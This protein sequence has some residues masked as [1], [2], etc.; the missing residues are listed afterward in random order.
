MNP[1]PE[2]GDAR[3]AAEAMD[4]RMHAIAGDIESVTFN[5][6]SA[7]VSRKT[8]ELRSNDVQSIGGVYGDLFDVGELVALSA[9]VCEAFI[10]DIATDRRDPMSAMV[11][12]YLQAAGVGVLMER[13][14][15]LRKASG[16]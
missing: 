4:A 14:R 5:I 12:I 15:W 9:G 13:E 3:R 1:L 16:K 8:G 6:A 11:S 7:S 10:L 2:K